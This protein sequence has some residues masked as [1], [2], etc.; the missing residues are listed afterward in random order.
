MAG[1]L[2]EHKNH[3]AIS[4]DEREYKDF[5]R[6]HVE[7]KKY[8]VIQSGAGAWFQEKNWDQ[9]KWLHLV[10]ELKAMGYAVYHIGT[11]DN[12]PLEGVVDFRGKT[13]IYESLLLVKH[14]KLLIGV[15][16]FAEQAAWVFNVPSVIL[17]GPTNP[18]Y[19]LNPGQVAVFSNQAF[20]Y[21]DLYN[22]P[23]QFQNMNSIEVKTVLKAASTI[24]NQVN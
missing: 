21:R 2:N 22:L 5:L 18:R 4:I 9:N 19:S 17:Y 8:L 11:Q 24:L 20:E 1:V 13:N 7:N 15:N 14:A 12:A 23:Y 3:Q 10:E 16:S 6:D